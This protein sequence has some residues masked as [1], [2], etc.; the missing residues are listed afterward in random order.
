MSSNRYLL[1]TGLPASGKSTWGKEL[2]ASLGWPLLDKDTYL[3][4]LFEQRGTGDEQW[5]SALSRE[6]DELF[7]ND[8]LQQKQAV[9]VSWWRHPD[10][11]SCS[12]TP[13]DWLLPHASTSAEIHIDCPPETAVQRF[14]GRTRHPGHR[15]DL[16]DA[17]EL[18]LVLSAYHALGPLAICAVLTGSGDVIGRASAWAGE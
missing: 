6:A 10:A 17:D 18:S 7:I 1:V 2:S 15:D 12:G 9:L 5:R 4:S 14:K 16:R 3:E 13:T 11:L 8:A